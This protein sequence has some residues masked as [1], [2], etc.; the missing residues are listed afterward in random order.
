[1]K[2][3]IRGLGHEVELPPD[4]IKHYAA[5]RLE[6]SQDD[7]R[8]VIVRSTDESFNIEIERM[9]ASTMHCDGP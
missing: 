9:L 5:T 3:I 8:L 2:G 1:M 7:Q 6:L 4:V